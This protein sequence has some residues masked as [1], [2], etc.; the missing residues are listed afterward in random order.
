MQVIKLAVQEYSL[1]TY[2]LA[3]S[4]PYIG[5]VDL[6]PLFNDDR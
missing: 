1:Y 4:R 2:F 5:I 6:G 3:T